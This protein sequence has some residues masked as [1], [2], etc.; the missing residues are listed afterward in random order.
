MLWL[1]GCWGFDCWGFVVLFVWVWCQWLVVFWGLDVGVWYRLVLG[2][3]FMFP[4]L[5][6]RVDCP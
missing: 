4:W 6:F 5:L 3:G 2:L 1:A